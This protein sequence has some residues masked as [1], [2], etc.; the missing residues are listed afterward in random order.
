VIRLRTKRRRW[1]GIDGEGMG[2][3]SHRY[4]M[5]ASS[6]EDVIQTQKGLSSKACLDFMLDLGTRDCRVCG[7]YL[8]YDWTMILRDLPE[9]AVYTLLRPELRA[10]TKEEGGGF[11]WIKWKGYRLHFLAGAMWIGHG[12]RRVTVWDLGKYYQGPFVDALHAW[13]LAPKV[14]EHIRA[15]KLGRAGFTWRSRK[16][17]LAYCLAEC[18]AL[19]DLAEHL[20]QA[21]IDAGLKPRS[22]HG[23][24]STAGSLLAR[25]SIGEK[26][27]AQPPEVTRAASIAFF[28]GRAEISCS[29]TIKRPV[30]AYDI[31]SAYPY[32][33]MHLP[34]LQHGQ[35][36][37]T[38]SERRLQNA[39][40]AVIAGSIDRVRADWGPLPIRLSSGSIVFPRGG[41][42]GYWWRDEWLSAQEWPHS[43]MKFD[44]AYIL[45]C[46]CECQPFAFIQDLFL[47][48]LRVGK[49]TGAGKV[50]KL[51]LNSLYGKLAQTVGSGQY[52][53]RVW[54]GMITSGTRAQVLNL[55]RDHQRLDSVVMVATDG[56][57]ST[58]ERATG[59]VQL[60]GWERTDHQTGVTLVRPGIYWTAEGKLRARGLG[61][62]SLDLA[63]EMMR[64][65]LER[66][67]DRVLLP[68]RI[69]FHGAKSSIYARQD[70]M[71]VRSARYGQWREIPTHVSLAP[72][73]KRRRDWGLHLLRDVQS[74]AYGAKNQ[75]SHARIFEFHQLLRELTQ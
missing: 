74:G 63:R 13:D 2:R 22:W 45:R 15:M 32:H 61:R 25:Y 49:N 37:R 56:V 21:H 12:D 36:V 43:R 16:K 31:T 57:F 69:V 27:G 38:R 3:K 53:S 6:D 65:A 8:S 35:W 26:R 44:H 67:D 17:I 55:M 28:G 9:G 51:A 64:E 50:L 59:P 19:A 41:A 47:E 52:A 34:C 30:Y 72:A 20:E 23:P 70:G 73:P 71:L 48:R 4:V 1:V 60:G 18:K 33:A 5:L 46:E 11:D 40:H 14:R 68:P 58:E 29:G 62:D 66:G 42:S 75:A 54:A 24:G 10:R 7:Y 39:A